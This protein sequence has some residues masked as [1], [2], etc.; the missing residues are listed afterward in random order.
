MPHLKQRADFLRVAAGRRRCA[1]PGVVLQVAPRPADTGASARVGY[2]ASRKVGNAVVRNRSRRR[3]RAAVAALLP[4][5]ADSALDY[6][7]IARDA[8]ATRAWPALLGDLEAAM[9]RLR[10]WRDGAAA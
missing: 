10:A 4:R 2:T 8:T 6:V 3:L 7:L 9:R 1:M 5:H